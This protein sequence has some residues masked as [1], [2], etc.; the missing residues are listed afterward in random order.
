LLELTCASTLT[1]PDPQALFW[2]R[3]GN[4]INAAFAVARAGFQESDG[5]FHAPQNLEKGG[6]G[7]SPC[8]MHHLKSSFSCLESV[9]FRTLSYRCRV[10]DKFSR[11]DHTKMTNLC[12]HD[13]D[14]GLTDLGEWILVLHSLLSSGGV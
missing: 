7:I 9:L 3:I 11:S 6:H 10:P 1:P 14:F 13:A 5:V 2:Q 12:V 8:T 4:H